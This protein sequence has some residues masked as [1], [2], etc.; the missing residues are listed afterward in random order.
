MRHECGVSTRS[1]F[2]V[3][4]AEGSETLTHHHEVLKCRGKLLL[5]REEVLS[6]P[7]FAGEELINPGGE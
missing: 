5:C 1:G 2:S 6:D 3:D 7:F 4:G